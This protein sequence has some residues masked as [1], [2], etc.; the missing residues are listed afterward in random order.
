MVRRVERI[1]RLSFSSALESKRV[2]RSHSLP[3]S[4]FCSISVCIA[5][6]TAKAS[7]TE[8]MVPVQRKRKLNTVILFFKMALS[9]TTRIAPGNVFIILEDQ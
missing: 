6:S 7:L 4:M 5:S 1:L 9:R 3:S 2:A 8:L